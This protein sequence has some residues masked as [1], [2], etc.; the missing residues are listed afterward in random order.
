MIWPANLASVTM[1][2]AMY[3]SGDGTDPTV[4]GGGLPRYTWF[5]IVT[6]ASFVYYFIPGFFVQCLSVF[7]F[8]TWM[9]P[10]NPVVNQLFGGITG[11]SII[12]I[13]FDWS[14]VSGY[15]GS[16]LVSPW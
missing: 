5:G 7:A 15:I 10:Q 3:E 12:P 2:N 13:T 16:P 9:A 8:A 1:M 4:F 6:A 14:Q 11:L